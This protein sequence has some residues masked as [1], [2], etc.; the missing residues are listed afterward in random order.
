MEPGLAAFDGDLR[1]E[2]AELHVA[3]S[4]FPGPTHV[5][6]GVVLPFIDLRVCAPAKLPVEQHT[7]LE[8]IDVHTFLDFF[9]TGD[10][11]GRSEPRKHQDPAEQSHCFLCQSHVVSSFPTS[12]PS[13]LRDQ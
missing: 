9:E 7:V 2:V 8:V 11:I 6:E 3:E 1:G 5:Q 4:Q 13:Q 12:A 10:R